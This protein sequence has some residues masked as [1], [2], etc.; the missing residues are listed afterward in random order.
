M[1][2]GRARY[3]LLQYQKRDN[4]SL[5]VLEWQVK[6]YRA[7]KDEELFQGLN[8]LG[9]VMDEKT[10]RGLSGSPEEIIDQ[11]A[12]DKR[13][14]SYL[15]LFEL[16][17][18]FRPD[19]KT[20]AIFCDELDA[21]IEG[22]QLGE[23]DE[24]LLIELF[25]ILDESVDQGQKPKAVFKQL[26][27][28]L[29]HDLESFFYH[30]I[31][32]QIKKGNET[33]ASELLEHIHEYTEGSLWLDF[34][35]IRLLRGIPSEDAFAMISRFL[36]KLKAQSNLP[37][38]FELLRYLI[39]TGHKELFIKTYKDILKQIKTED[40]FIEMLEII[41]EFYSL[42][43]LEKEENLIRA[44]ILE[45]KTIPLEQKIPPEDKQKL[46]QIL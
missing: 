18:R 33:E 27:N 6:D 13:E 24:S 10:L 23:Q 19:Q 22:Y 39:E 29:A 42:N 34:L 38:S 15:Y 11:L 30:Y 9:L 32:D 7:L 5:D 1:L 37:L 31:Y 4:P 25:D 20:V 44:L 36:E 40:H 3:N 12:E 26:S 35:R 43:D 8:R 41:F 2:L 46:S 17:R 21:F 28:Y 14:E 16:W 45:R